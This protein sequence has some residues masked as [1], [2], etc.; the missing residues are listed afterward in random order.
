MTTNNFKGTKI[1]KTASCELDGKKSIILTLFLFAC[2]AMFGQGNNEGKQIFLRT[3]IPAPSLKGNMVGTSTT[4]EISIHLPFNYHNSKKTYPVVYFLAGFNTP[5]SDLVHDP[6][7]DSLIN[8][9]HVQDMI[10]VEIS[11]YNLFGGGMYA[12]SPVTG[13]WEDYVVND[14]IKYI[15]SN[16][17]TIPE[18]ASRGLAGHSMGGGG[19]MRISMKYPDLFSVAYVMSPKISHENSYMNFIFSDSSNILA[20]KKLES[21]MRKS[22]KAEYITNL[23][24]EL[25]KCDLLTHIAMAHGCAYAPDKNRPLMMKLP[26]DYYG[27]EEYKIKQEVYHFWN[28]AYDNLPEKVFLYKENIKKY[29]HYTIECGYQDEL[30]W[31][32]EGTKKYSEI[33]YKYNIPHETKFFKGTHVSKV[34][35]RI[36]THLL[37]TMSRYLKTK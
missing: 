25:K 12:N 8:N 7:I 17:R 21:K 34:R 27:Q 28:A 19:A 20:L 9:K 16:F 3:T 31:I 18:R 29:A 32:L 33:L 15:D 5:S 22:S 11:G 10:Y 24:A 6:R 14:V 36:V 23:K 1:S 37:P 35:E 4:Q 30:N 13:N 2:F 26:F